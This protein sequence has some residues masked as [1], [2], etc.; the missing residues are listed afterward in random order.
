MNLHQQVVIE[1]QGPVSVVLTLDEIIK[2][3]K[4]TNHYQIFVLSWLSEFFRLGY[5]SAALQL[6]NPVVIGSDTTKTANIEALKAMSP[7]DQVALAEF[8]KASIAHGEALV[9]GKDMDTVAW[10]RFVTHSQD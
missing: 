9:K 2:A 6:E 4:V 5:K 7:A 3:G 8:L 10:M 1:A